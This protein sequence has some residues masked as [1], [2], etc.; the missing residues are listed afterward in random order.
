MA[1]STVEGK[2]LQKGLS[3]A[4][5]VK[6]INLSS[7]NIK[8]GGKVSPGETIFFMDQLALMLETGTPFK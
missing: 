8:L 2:G 7:L 1:I 6:A 3:I 4:E 5:W